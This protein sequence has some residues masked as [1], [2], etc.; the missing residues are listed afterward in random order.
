MGRTDSVIDD[1]KTGECARPV[2]HDLTK[3]LLRN[4]IFMNVHTL[5]VLMGMDNRYNR[6]GDHVQHLGLPEKLEATLGI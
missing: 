1:L 2:L 3:R 5:F 6:S 4:E